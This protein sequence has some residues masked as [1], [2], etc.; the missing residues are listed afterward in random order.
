MASQ[1]NLL[2]IPPSLQSSKISHVHKT[3]CKILPLRD[4]T[5]ILP[6]FLSERRRLALTLRILFDRSY[7]NAA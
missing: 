4:V 3:R 2:N 5:N 6:R 1:L 7:Q